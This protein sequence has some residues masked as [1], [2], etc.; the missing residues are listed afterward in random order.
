[1][2]W[3]VIIFNSADKVDDL[4]E[5]NSDELEPINFGQVFEKYFK[6]IKIDGNHRE[7]AGD[8]FTINYFV[9]DAS[10]TNFMVSLYG[11][12]AIYAIAHLAKTN[13]WQVFDTGLG[14]M[15]DIDDPAK[16]GYDDFQDYLKTIW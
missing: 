11:E 16:N 8:D 6:H 3:D 12:N 4:D 2:S 14:E 5:I 13:G 7:A 9:D 10:S 15:L 1:M